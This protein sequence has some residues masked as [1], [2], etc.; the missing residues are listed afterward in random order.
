[1]VAYCLLYTAAEMSHTPLLLHRHPTPTTD[2]KLSPLFVK[3]T[4]SAYNTVLS[5]IRG[6]VGGWGCG[7]TT[8]KL[9]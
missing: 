6:G 2:K 1:M 9:V 8:E 3:F 4:P 5:P 7:L